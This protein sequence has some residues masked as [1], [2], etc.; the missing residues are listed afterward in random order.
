[1]AV[2]DKLFSIKS[3]AVNDKVISIPFCSG[4]LYSKHWV[5]FY[6]TI[7]KGKLTGYFRHR[8]FS[9]NDMVNTSTLFLFPLTTTLIGVLAE[10]SKEQSFFFGQEMLWF[11]YLSYTLYVIF[12]FWDATFKSTSTSL[13]G[14]KM[15]LISDFP[16][17][18]VYFWVIPSFN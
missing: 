14:V 1:M 7:N 8:F 11:V 5:E 6:N 18:S 17:N 15:K 16:F 10:M 4:T 13:F 3:R 9:D 2:I 12:P